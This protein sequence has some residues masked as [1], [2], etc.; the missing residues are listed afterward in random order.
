MSQR[1]NTAVSLELLTVLIDGGEMKRRRMLV[2][3]MATMEIFDD[4]SAAQMEAMAKN[5]DNVFEMMKYADYE[6][7]TMMKQD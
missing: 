3:V 7:E 1:E 2:V 6:N 4:I 5:C